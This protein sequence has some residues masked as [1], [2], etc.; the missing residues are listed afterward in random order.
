VFLV[1]RHGKELLDLPIAEVVVADVRK[2]LADVQSIYPKT[3][4]RA[5]AGVATIFDYAKALGL[6]S[7]DN[8]ASRDVFRYLWPPAPMKLHRRSM[9]F[10]DVP[11]FYRRLIVRGST[12]SLALAF[13]ILAATRTQEILGARW[14]EVDLDTRLWVIPLKRM[15]ARRERR[16]PLSDAGVDILATMRER[17]PHAD[18][19][20]AADHFCRDCCTTRWARQRF[21]SWVSIELF[22]GDARNDFLRARAH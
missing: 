16:I 3:A 6:R 8:P 20:F 18:Y 11:A 19:L 1:K 22:D 10:A 21:R 4:K 13:V 14:S 17:R 12:T 2:A 5:L 15:K 9:A 7:G